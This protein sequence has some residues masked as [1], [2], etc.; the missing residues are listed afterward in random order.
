MMRRTHVPRL[1]SLNPISIGAGFHIPPSPVEQAAPSLVNKAS[2]SPVLV[3]G[4]GG[5]QCHW[6]I[7]A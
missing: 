4:V 3:A 6:G 2:L 1:K 5:S 7:L